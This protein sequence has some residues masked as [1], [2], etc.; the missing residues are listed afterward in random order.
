MKAEPNFC[1]VLKCLKLKMVGNASCTLTTW[2]SSQW[3]HT[4]N[5]GPTSNN[6]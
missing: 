5:R 3:L 6:Y 1:P 4:Q 2:K